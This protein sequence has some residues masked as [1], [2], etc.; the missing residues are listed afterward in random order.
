MRFWKQFLETLYLISTSIVAL[1]L[2]VQTFALALS[3]ILFV[4]KRLIFSSES[5][6]SPQ[7]KF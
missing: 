6:A 5:K 1:G 7:F 4:L 2:N 3:Y